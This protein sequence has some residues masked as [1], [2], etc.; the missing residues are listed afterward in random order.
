MTA[1][2]GFQGLTGFGSSDTTR[3]RTLKCALMLWPPDHTVRDLSIP[4]SA[5]KSLGESDSE[6]NARICNLAIRARI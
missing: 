1:L 3:S 2:Q 6:L 5:K 4:I